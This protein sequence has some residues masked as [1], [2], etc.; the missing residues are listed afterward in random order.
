MGNR[1]TWQPTDDGWGGEIIRMNSW[2]L[3]IYDDGRYDN[4]LAYNRIMDSLVGHLNNPEGVYSL[5]PSDSR[6][7][8]CIMQDG[9]YLFLRS[10][11]T[12]MDGND[13]RPMQEIYAS[14]YQPLALEI[15]RELNDPANRT[16]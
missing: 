10:E 2:R 6:S 4:W 16:T 7:S 11:S 8:A 1:F 15:I 12:D 3:P 14:F 13:D 9:N 5:S